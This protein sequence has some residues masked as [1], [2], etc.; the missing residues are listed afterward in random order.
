MKLGC[1][2]GHVMVVQTDYLPYSL[3]LMQ[4]E[5]IWTA[6]E[7]VVKETKSLEDLTNEAEHSVGDKFLEFFSSISKETYCCPVCG[8]LYIQNQNNS[9]LFDCY[10]K[11]EI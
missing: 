2:C 1:R 7:L 6:W 11:E 3:S 10:V 5:A 8:R 9:N 4:S